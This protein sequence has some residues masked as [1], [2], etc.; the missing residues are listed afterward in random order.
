MRELRYTLLTDGSS[1]TALL[2]ILSWTLKRHVACPVQA[3]WAD[4]RYLPQAP[5]ILPDRFQ[6]SLDLIPGDQSLQKRID[7]IHQGLEE[8][9]Q[10]KVMPAVCVIPIRMTEAWLLI[11]ERAVRRAAGNPNGR[12]A[13][14]LPS[15]EALEHV[16]DPKSVLYDCLKEASGLSGS[17]RK[18]FRVTESAQRISEFI[19]DF[20]PL[21]SLSAFVYLENSIERIVSEQGW[22]QD[23]TVQE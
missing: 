9:G 21:R 18:R 6:T 15:V 20:T 16:S 5:I 10:W 3:T 8:A 13:L 1:D 4:L 2:P 7:E 23:V 14:D 22:T 19:E 17:R 12:E 11:D